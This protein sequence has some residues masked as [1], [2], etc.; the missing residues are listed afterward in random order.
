MADPEKGSAIYHTTSLYNK[1]GDDCK[2][3]DTKNPRTVVVISYKNV[4]GFLGK[5]DNCRD[6][7]KGGSNR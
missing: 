4:R 2:C 3:S 7:E 1:K 5:G 6:K